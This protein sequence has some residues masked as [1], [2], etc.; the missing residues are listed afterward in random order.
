M[1][2]YEDLRVV[3]VEELQ[4]I[5]NYAEKRIKEI[6]IVQVEEAKAKTVIAIRELLTACRSAGVWKLGDI[7]WECND[8]DEGNYFDI[9]DDDILKDVA[10]ILEGKGE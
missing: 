1:I 7:Y 2:N 4:D 8:C 9:L 10:N 5:I 3:G 6:A